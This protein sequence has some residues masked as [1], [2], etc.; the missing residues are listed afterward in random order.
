[1]ITDPSSFS[2]AKASLVEKI[3]LTP[4]LREDSTADE[5]PPLPPQVTTDPSSFSA[6]NA[7]SLE[8]IWLTPEL[9]ED[10]TADEL[11]PEL[12]EPQVMTDPS[13]FS[14]AKAYIFL[15]SPDV[16]VPLVTWGIGVLVEKPPS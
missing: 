5:L 15:N 4:E 2:A 16:L 12:E 7:L 14:A 3:W 6:A 10:S 11:L 8:N 9:R 1:M 13:S